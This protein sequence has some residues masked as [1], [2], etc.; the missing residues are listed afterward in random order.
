MIATRLHA[1]RRSSSPATRQS[2]VSI[3]STSH[4]RTSKRP[5]EPIQNIDSDYNEDDDENELHEG[6][7]VE[8]ISLTISF[9]FRLL[10]PRTPRFYFEPIILNIIF[11][12]N[13]SIDHFFFD[14]RIDGLF[15]IVLFI[16]LA[17][18][19]HQ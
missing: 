12:T 19:H 11:S 18:T 10:T 14:D 5:S 1:P 8:Y 17:H 3:H 7:K 6:S 13:I 15:S 9:F 2:V 16:I 4:H